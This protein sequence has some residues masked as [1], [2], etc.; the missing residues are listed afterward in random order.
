MLH[1]ERPKEGVKSPRDEATQ[2]GNWKPN[3]GPL[4]EKQLLLTVESY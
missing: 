1:P 2:H 4:Q 3:S